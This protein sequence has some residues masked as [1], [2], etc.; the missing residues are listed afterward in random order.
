[1]IT[2]RLRGDD[3]VL[4]MLEAETGDP[5]IV[6]V[7]GGFVAEVLHRYAMD[8]GVDAEELWSRAMLALAV[9]NA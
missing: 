9:E 4:A 8:S 7:L 1:M 6:N 3:D 5:P 2:A